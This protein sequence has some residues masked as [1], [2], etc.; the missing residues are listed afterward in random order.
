MR[1]SLSKLLVAVG[2]ISVACAGMAVRTRWWAEGIVVLT[3]G[4]F[5]VAALRAVVLKGRDRCFT[6]AFAAVGGGYLLLAFSSFVYS[7]FTETSLPNHLLLYLASAMRLDFNEG[8]LQYYT[9]P[10]ATSSP[11]IPPINSLGTLSVTSNTSGDPTASATTNQY[12]DPLPQPVP[13]T[14]PNYSIPT[15]PPAVSSSTIAAGDSSQPPPPTI[16]VSPTIASSGSWTPSPATGNS[17]PADIP[18]D[19]LINNNTEIGRFFIIGNCVW[20]WLFALLAGWF[21][22]YLYSKRE[23]YKTA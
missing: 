16:T 12:S 14:I 10:V 4:L 19:R 5:V 3:V 11:A 23:S 17:I 15:V 8:T 22:G 7:I 20:A 6:I 9:A 21:C 2:L 18:Y 13:V 1:F